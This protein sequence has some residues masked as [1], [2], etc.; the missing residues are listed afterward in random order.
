MLRLTAT[1]KVSL[2]SPLFVDRPSRQEGVWTLQALRYPIRIDDSDVEIALVG[3]YHVMTR[4]DPS[5]NILRG[6]IWVVPR[7]RVS[8]SRTET[9]EPPPIRRHDDRATYFYERILIY[10]KVALT[11]LCRF[12]RFFKY[13]QAHALLR[14]A[15]GEDLDNPSWTDETGQE[16]LSVVDFR[17]LSLYGIELDD[18]V[19][20]QALATAD[21]PSLQQ[22]LAEPPI[23]PALYEELLSDAHAALFQGGLRRAILELAISCEVAIKQAFFAKATE[24]ALSV[25]FD[26]RRQVRNTVGGFTKL[27]G[28]P[29]EHLLGQNFWKADKRA[30]IHI[31][32]LFQCRNQIAHEGHPAYRNTRGSLRPVDQTVAKEWFKAADRLFTWLRHM[33]P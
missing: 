10:R 9:I 6:P 16:V 30:C 20:I 24:A 23:K 5:G 19:G 3:G 2:A 31:D 21:D 33:Q 14:D 27:L 26:E 12:L 28:K 11:T 1:F 25:Y 7:V 32:H 18:E 22:A 15:I 4:M 13:R 8:V 17:T 29:A